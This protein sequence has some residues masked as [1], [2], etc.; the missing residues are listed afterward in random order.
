MFFFGNSA[1]VNP[2]KTNSL[3]GDGGGEMSLL[4]PLACKQFYK[5]M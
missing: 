1:Q 2:E 4:S 5:S 3:V